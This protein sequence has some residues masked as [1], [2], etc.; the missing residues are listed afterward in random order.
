MLKSLPPSAG[1]QPMLP[2]IELETLVL[3][4]FTDA[5]AAEVGLVSVDSP[6]TSSQNLAAASSPQ[7]SHKRQ[8]RTLSGAANDGL[9][10]VPH[11]EGLEPFVRQLHA[12]KLRGRRLF[13]EV[14]YRV[15]CLAETPTAIRQPVWCLQQVLDRNGDKPE[16][17]G[18]RA[19]ELH[20]ALAPSMRTHYAVPTSIAQASDTYLWSWASLYVAEV[21]LHFP[22]DEVHPVVTSNLGWLLRLG[23]DYC[24][25][26]GQHNQSDIDTTAAAAATAGASATSNTTVATLSTQHQKGLEFAGQ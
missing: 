9:K 7:K 21:V 13:L 10:C 5:F 12:S 8:K 14:L 15:S 6:L 17:L 4:F 18:D 19:V 2:E 3:A 1:A 20:Q 23:A 26:A 11:G 24:M 25:D 22:G 16:T